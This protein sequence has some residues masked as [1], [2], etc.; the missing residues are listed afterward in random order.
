[1]R[2]VYSTLYLSE[3]GELFDVDYADSSRAARRFEDKIKTDKRI[4]KIKDA[5]EEAFGKGQYASLI[6]VFILI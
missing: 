3:I 2:F 5:V 1:M 4:L 6:S